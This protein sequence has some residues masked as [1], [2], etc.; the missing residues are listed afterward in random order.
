MNEETETVAPWVR[1]EIV[2]VTLSAYFR[3]DSRN[4]LV[5]VQ[6]IADMPCI[7]LE[8]VATDSNRMSAGI[9]FGNPLSEIRQNA[10]GLAVSFGVPLVDCTL[11]AARRAQ[12]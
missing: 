2:S 8:L 4:D 1:L 5:L 12:M 10:V 11:P 9:I 7:A 3:E 6:A